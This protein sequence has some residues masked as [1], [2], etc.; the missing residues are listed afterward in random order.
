MLLSAPAVPKDAP[1]SVAMTPQRLHKRKEVV[2]RQMVRAHR[3]ITSQALAPGGDGDGPSPR[4]A[5]MMVPTV[6]DGRVPAR[7]PRPAD[8]RLQHEARCSNEAEGALL[9]VGFFG[10]GATG[11]RAR[12]PGRRHR[13]HGPAWQAS[14][15]SSP[16]AAAHARGPRGKR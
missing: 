16:A 7:R 14:E 10:V 4:E 6:M 8:R 12:W 1:W 2:T 13:A 5:I 15:G 3:T 11:L 9:A